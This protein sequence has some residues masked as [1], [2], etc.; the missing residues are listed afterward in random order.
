MKTK[1][2]GSVPTDHFLVSNNK[3]TGAG[4]GDGWRLGDYKRYQDNYDAIFRKK[5]KVPK[6]GTKSV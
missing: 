1:H 2:W 3:E 5:G 6:K 4:K